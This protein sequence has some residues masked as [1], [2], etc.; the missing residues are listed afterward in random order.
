[1]LG[2]LARAFEALNTGAP[3]QLL[4]GMQTMA[5]DVSDLKERIRILAEKLEAL[6]QTLKATGKGAIV[7]FPQV[8]PSMS[9]PTILEIPPYPY[10]HFLDLVGDLVVAWGR[11]ATIGP[12]TGF[13]IRIST[14]RYARIMNP[15]YQ[16]ITLLAVD[17]FTVPVTIAVSDRADAVY[18]S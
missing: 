3:A 13:D 8:M 5:Q 9:V 6:N 1:M 14:G 15:G 18:G 4:Q 12:N 2:D 17:P 7:Y 10:V 16:A 11:S